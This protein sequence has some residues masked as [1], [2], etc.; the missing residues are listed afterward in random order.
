[1]LTGKQKQYLKSIAVSYPAVVQIGKEGI[2]DS[3]VESVSDVLEARELIKIKIN[4]NSAETI[5]E[6]A[7]LL[8]EKLHCEIVQIIGRNCILF[9]KKTD[10]KKSHFELP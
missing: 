4:R 1:M 9:K 8:S 7:L 10:E 5:K 6:T 3:V 2:T